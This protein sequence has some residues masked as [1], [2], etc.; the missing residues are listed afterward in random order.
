M[1]I[2]NRKTQLTDL[3][4]DR[5]RKTIQNSLINNGLK[6]YFSQPTNEEEEEENNNNTNK[7]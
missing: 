6:Q 5:E 3:L 7:L 4:G 1:K 2:A